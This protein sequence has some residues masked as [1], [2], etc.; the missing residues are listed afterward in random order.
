[1]AGAAGGAGAT[2]ARLR[3]ALGGAAGGS[4]AFTGAASDLLAFMALG[5]L[6]VGALLLRAA[7]PARVTERR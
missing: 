4:L 2:F 3:S 5:L 7:R 6:M 1:L